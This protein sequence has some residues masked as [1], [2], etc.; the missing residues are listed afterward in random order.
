MKSLVIPPLDIPTPNAVISGSRFVGYCDT[1]LLTV[2]SVEGNVGKPLEYQW[3][4]LS[5][6][7]GLLLAVDTTSTLEI[8]PSN[9]EDFNQKLLRIQL[10]SRNW[11]CWLLLSDIT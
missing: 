9:L 10:H 5:V 4:V 2:G 11:V 1:L 6:D 8:S 7:T 3:I